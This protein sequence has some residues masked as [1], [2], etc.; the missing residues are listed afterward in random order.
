MKDHN[1]FPGVNKKNILKCYLLKFLPSM[2]SVI[3]FY[4]N[5]LPFFEK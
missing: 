4:V 3:L 2:L 1:L 5:H